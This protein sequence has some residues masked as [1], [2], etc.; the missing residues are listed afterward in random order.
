MI[1]KTI[2]KFASYLGLTVVSKYDSQ[3]Q[4]NYINLLESF[5]FNSDQLTNACEIIIFSKDRALQLEALIR[6]YYHYSINP[7]RL[8]ILYSASN[9]S[10]LEGYDKL[11]KQFSD[12]SI[13]FYREQDFKKDLITLIE[14]IKVSK[15]LFLVDDIVFKKEFDCEVFTKI[16][17]KIEL[18]S[19]R[20]GK[21]LNYAYTVQ[22]KQD[23]P[24]L[25]TYSKLENTLTWSWENSVQDWAYP[26][27]LDGHLFDTLE[28]KTLINLL[29]F[30]APNSLFKKR[31]GICY[32]LSIIVNNPCNKVQVEHD[33]FHGTTDASFLN[34]EWLN[35]KHID[36]AP[37]HE[38]ENAS[39]HQ[40]LPLKLIDQ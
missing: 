4:Q 38:I 2:K 13:Q 19:L 9:A 36:L 25:K 34:S 10:F 29:D 37:F 1:K 21:H 22:K 32:P 23:L 16:E 6:S 31:R 11:I 12:K 7:V 40:E 20:H 3:R 26:L 24:I 33:N 15:V 14:S 39:V 17:P 35:G 5:C 8:K 27:S 18:L 30:K 28:M